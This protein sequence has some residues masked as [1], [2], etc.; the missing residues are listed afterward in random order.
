MHLRSAH[1]R[2]I[3]V[4]VDAHNSEIYLQHTLTSLLSQTHTDLEIIIVD[5]GSTDGSP[6]IIRDFAASDHRIHP[7]FTPHHGIAHAMNTGIAA[8]SGDYIAYLD[9][10]DIALP[11][12]LTNQLAWMQ[13][14]D[15][16]ICG[17]C[18]KR[19]GDHS[20]LMWFPE[21]HKSICNELLFS[22]SL[23]QTGVMLRAEV[24][25]Q[26]PYDEQAIFLDYELWTR[27]ATRYRMGNI[28]QVLTL[29]RSHSR[30]TSLLMKAEF[31]EDLR[32]YREPLFYK[33]FP[34]ASADD[35]AAL[36]RLIDN[37]P[38]GSLDELEHAG[39][40]LSKLTQSGDA[41][42][43]DK[44]A[45]RWWATC[46]RNAPLDVGCYQIYRN[47]TPMFGSPTGNA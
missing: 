17:S 33:L 15:L 29:Y 30:Q 1:Y 42:L 10:D 2:L 5:D 36:S 45:R 46:Y 24:A 32:I 27:L 44:M 35:Y 3:S 8:A 19:I 21:K 11:V 14:N 18:V 34:D 26:N 12:R 43:N 25:K 41:F 9:H 39:M 6:D 31:R 16:D 40:L 7:I 23:L 37:I 13:K 47:I 20:N 4:V 28:Q 38:M 22:C